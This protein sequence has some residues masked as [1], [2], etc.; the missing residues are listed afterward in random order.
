[1]KFYKLCLGMLCC[2]F[3]AF[4]HAQTALETSLSDLRTLQGQF[5]QKLYNEKNELVETSQ[6]KMFIQRPDKFHW[7]Y[8]QPYQ[9]LIIADSERVWIY[10]KDLEQVTVKNLKKALGNTPA[11]IFSSHRKLEE[12]FFINS[13]PSQA[14]LTRFELVPK[15]AQAQFENIKIIMQDKEL[16]GL[17]LKDN[18]GQT[19]LISFEQIKRNQPLDE[20][21]FIFT[22][23]A[24]TDIVEE[25]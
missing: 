19:T 23:P 6:G 7:D 12:D 14:G 5:K 25:K 9:Q 10:D 3:S 16:N 20:T 8:Q 1:M 13:L 4:L 24:G 17:E 15:D 18:L 21:L 22:P 11:L 2:G